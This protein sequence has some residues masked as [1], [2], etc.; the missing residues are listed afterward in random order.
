MCLCVCFYHRLHRKFC[1]SD[2]SSIM[3][4]PNRIVTVTE[5]T[6]DAGMAQFSAEQYSEVVVNLFVLVI[7]VNETC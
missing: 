6:C 1:D 4:L 3:L 2:A 5:I 7:V